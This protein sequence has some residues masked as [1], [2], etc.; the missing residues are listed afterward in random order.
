LT[1]IRDM[2]IPTI[3]KLPNSK[4]NKSLKL[5]TLVL[6]F[7]LISIPSISCHRGC[8]TNP[9]I[10]TLSGT[11]FNITGLQFTNPSCNCGSNCTYVLR[12][13]ATPLAPYSCMPPVVTNSTYVSQCSGSCTQANCPP[14]SANVSNLCPGVTYDIKVELRRPTGALAGSCS[15]TGGLT[16]NNTYNYGNYTPPTSPIAMSG[17]S[18]SNVV[19]SCPTDPTPAKPADPVLNG[20]TS[21]LYGTTSPTPT[22]SE[23]STG[24]GCASD[25]VIT[26]TWEFTNVCGA[27]THSCS[28][29][30]TK[31]RDNSNPSITC[32]SNITL[33]CNGSIPSPNPS[34]VVAT[35]NCSTPTVV[36]RGD[37]TTTNSCT[38]TINRYYRA[39][40]AC[41]NIADCLQVIT[42]PI[43]NTAPS[44][45]SPASGTTPIACPATPVFTAPVFAD[46]C[47]TVT[48]TFTDVDVAGA[49]PG[50]YTRTRTYTGTD[51]CGNS[52]NSSFAIVVEDNTN[53]TVTTAASGTTPIACPATPVF[54]AP[55]FA[56]ACGTVTTTFTD[57]DVA[58]ACPGTY[59]RTRT[60]TGTDACGNSVNSSFAIVVE[61]NTNPTVTTA[62]SGTTPIACPATPVFTAPVFS[63]ACGTVTTT[64]TDVDVAGACPGTYTRT[65]TYTGTDAC[66]NSV[67]SSFAIVVEDNA[68]PIWTTAAG[69]LDATVDCDDATSLANAQAL[70]PTATDLCDLDVSNIVKTSGAFTPGA[71]PQAG[72]Y[73]NTWT[74]TDDCGNLSNTFTQTISVQ[75]TI[76]PS[77][78]TPAG[79]LDATVECSDTAGY[80]FV[81]MQRPNV[82]DNCTPLSGLTEVVVL[83]SHY[84]QPAC[85]YS[86]IHTHKFKWVDACGNESPI[87]TMTVNIVDTTK[88]TW[89]TAAGALDATI[90]CDDATA[91]ANAQALFPVATDLCDLD[92]TNI[93][94][95]SG[96]FTPGACPQAGTYTNTWTVA[97][98]CGNTSAVYTQV[99]TIEDNDAPTWTT[100]A[101]ALDATVDCDD[102]TALA[103]AQALFPI[104]TDLCDLDVSNIVKT[105]GA[106]TPGAC[107]QAGTYTNTW[108]VAD[109][110]GNT[111]AVFTQTITIE[112]NDAPTWT[113]AAGALDATIDCDDATALTNAQALFPTAT[114]LCDL[115]VSNIVKTSG[116]FTPGACPQAGTYTNTWTVA[117]D[118]GNVSAVYT[119]VITIEDNDAPTW[120][121]AAGALD[122]TIDCDDATALTNTQALFP[123]AIDLCDLDVSNIVKTS[124]AFTPGACPQAGTYTNTWTV[125]DDCGNTS[126][127]Y[128]QVITIEDNDAPTWTIAAG[129]LDA[130]IDCDDATAL[131]NTQALFPVAIDLCDLDVS[132]IVKTSGAFT[133]SACPQA[134]TYTN[135]WTVADDC[136][137][138]SAV[139]TQVI[140]IEDNDAPNWTTAAGALD[141]TID[142]DDAT[143]LTTAQAL[144]P[145][146]TDLCDLDVSNIMKTSGAFTPGACPQVGTYTNT[147]TVADD[148]GNTSAVFTQVITIEDNDAPTWTTVAG[149]LDAT[150]DCD[151]AT[152]LTNAQALFPT[153][154]DL[155]DLDVSNIVKTS[156]AFTPGACPQAGTYTNTWTVADD[157]GNTSV[158]FTQVITIEDN[159]APTWTTAAG[160]LDATLDCDD[161]TALAT[162]QALFPVATDLCDLDVSNIVKTSG[163]FTPGACPQAGTYTNTWIVA[164]DCGN[165]SAVFTQ[166][167]TIEDNDAPTWTTTAGALDATIDCDDATALTNAQ[168]LFPAATDLCD[169]DVTNIIKV[170]GA[171]TPGACPQ[172]GTYTNTWTVADDCGNTSA[173]FTQTITI[174]DNDAPTWTT[175]AGALD[176]TIDCDDATA[177]ANAQ[178]LFPVATDLCDL[179][180]TNIIKVSG[181]FTP[182]ACPQAGTYTNTWTVADD[183]GNVSAVYNQVIT[184]EDNDAPTWT[185]AAG[186]LDAT[187][188]CDDA[189]ALANAQALFPVATDLCDLDVSNIVKTSGA[190]T[191]G[192]CPQAGTYTNTWT[193][194]DDCGNVSAVYT[195]VITIEDNDA[196]TWTTAAG[197]LDAT[198]DCDDATALTNAQ[199]LF[200]A[201]TDLCD[202]D[203]TNI[204][205]LSG[206]FTPG[207]CPQAGTYTN[208]WTVADDCGNVSAVYTQVITIEDN[209]APTWTTVAGALDA[210][211]DCDD[212]TALATAQALFPVATDLCDLDVTNIIKV[213]G[214]F[215]PGACPQAG[216]YTNTWT[217][218]D[219]CGNV[220]AVYT[221]VITI[222]D[223]DAPTWTT[224]AGALDATIDCDDAT[225]LANAQALFPVATDLCDLDV[226]NIVK[227]SGAFTPGACPQAGTYTNT[228]TV[229]D[230]CGNV[231][232]V[233]TQVITI[234]DND[235]PTWTTAAGALDATIDCDDATALTN[236]Q[237]LFPTATDL[238]DL[239]VSNIVKT[240]GAFTPG[241]CPQ[242][243]TYTNTWTV[244]DDC[245]N[246]SAVFTQVI[247]IEDNDAPTWT[248]AAGALDATIDCDDATALTN[249]QALF[250]VATDLCDLDVSNIVKTSGAFTPGA[251]PQA[252]TYTNTWTVADDCGNTSV[253]FTQTIT[254][255]DNDAPVIASAPADITLS[256]NDSLPGIPTLTATDNC[257]MSLS[258]AIF[259]EDPYTPSCLGYTITRRWNITDAC[260]NV[261][262]ERVQ[263]INIAATNLS[264]N[265]IVSA[266]VNCITGAVNIS[267]TADNSCLDSNSILGIQLVGC[268]G[269]NAGGDSVG[270]IKVSPATFNLIGSTDI[271]I[272]A[273]ILNGG[274]VECSG[275]IESVNL[276]PTFCE[277]ALPVKYDFIKVIPNECSNS[278]VWRTLEEKNTASFVIER[279]DDGIAFI[280]IGSISAKNQHLSYYTFLD[281]Q[282][283]NGTRD[284]YYRIKQIDIDQQYS[285]SNV[286][287]VS[288][289][290]EQESFHVRVFPNPGESTVNVDITTNQEM[291]TGVKIYDL[292]GQIVRFDQQ[293]LDNGTH[294]FLFNI[295]D[296]ATSHYIINIINMD[297]QKVLKSVKFR[298]Q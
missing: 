86:E 157:C 51:A 119:Q 8:L 200:P 111:S 115:D 131:T 267:A 31:P 97:D 277:F 237:A 214:V 10:G 248:T 39:T 221:Q 224:A 105:S 246:V 282:L 57:V 43:D 36:H 41:G 185:T 268:A 141:A 273:V 290:C 107:P 158:V 154:T 266:D 170:S 25:I 239:D 153:A 198:I 275:L 104:A 96:A 59:T 73:T 235:A 87:W 251:C 179:D 109:D 207:A 124:G 225:A 63:D 146:A 257:D 165:T 40:D 133:P 169:L 206:T 19:L 289:D 11:S 38:Q 204:T 106:F 168:A 98:D 174:E 256:C 159:D 1:T 264:L 163:A 17:C 229:T 223:N 281:N 284:Y 260:G 116:A 91:L 183:C 110:C 69:A 49:C 241:A 297:E 113:T 70:I 48:T 288:N 150:I 296:L 255:E 13:T 149:A 5:L 129:A 249:A 278:I 197:A 201:A 61:D 210:T 4:I 103:T 65:R 7:V 112:D 230:D 37:L 250:P 72:T 259:S 148:C 180:V 254:I 178:A 196:P 172:A 211:I 14:L 252:G 28:Y 35:D 52:V 23:T 298:K 272:A 85:S 135:T 62:A 90:D 193:V 283:D 286:F 270:T 66:G 79:S 161:A 117:D 152:A 287:T 68:A 26:R 271:S 265:T 143:A 89:T 50:T 42:R 202:L 269:C 30:I 219:D 33:P 12:V 71:C 83:D 190:F 134:G 231:S 122:V 24:D 171:F 240:S 137:N 32:P 102:A 74:V 140:T 263:N 262:I 226:S 144:F 279:S 108:T 29:T 126:A 245:G 280:E 238:C 181:A 261:A 213:S 147:W 244:A 191:P 100:A 9:G 192:A 56:D 81:H 3:K 120:T 203:V 45:N 145:V 64:F 142:C 99:I 44:I 123:V 34:A 156:G 18:F 78:T 82:S 84:V 138:V 175:A 139:Y 199:A 218:A 22:Y 54:T 55:V 234:E 253:V 291:M 189:T 182:G 243:G 194:A 276:S 94:K 127:V 15:L 160:A 242:A 53:P 76:G 67:N 128:T 46:A 167:I 212:A 295:S 217:V 215:T 233:Y 209:D 93:I 177:L 173:V 247:T 188:D 80:M 92:V 2:M 125:A 114:D 136:G 274:N 162:A 236:A 195:Q 227:T 205:K 16:C 75:D 6:S 285:Y 258:Q 232:A 166:T 184:I 186:A 228:W 27:V 47:G 21:C 292:L 155:C 88:P 222:E 20:A 208:T 293:L 220:S 77:W 130:T 176:A 60:Y 101:G 121:T 151:D 132:N 216:T 95:V 118:C 58:G 294:R 164:D 187:L